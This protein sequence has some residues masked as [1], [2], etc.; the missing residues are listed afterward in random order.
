MFN[1]FFRTLLEQTEA[2]LADLLA[3]KLYLEWGLAQIDGL[4]I[5][6]NPAGV[7][8]LI[9]KGPELLC[10]EI[11]AKIR[12]EIGLTEEERKNF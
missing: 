8:L 12:A 4:T 7:E 11:V 1:Y 3:K 9:S 5:D 6:G 2:A 10:D